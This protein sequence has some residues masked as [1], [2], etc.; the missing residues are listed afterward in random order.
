[1]KRAILFILITFLF[2]F[3]PVSAQ[4]IK[5]PE[6]VFGFQM[7]TDKKLINWQQIVSYFNLLAENSKRVQVVELGRTTLNRPM[8]MAIIGAEEALKNLE[9]YQKIQ[10]QLA[11][12]SDL[13][14]TNV[15]TLIQEGKLVFLITLNIHSTEI[16]SSQESVELAYEL[17]TSKDLEI[18]KILDNVI[19]LLVPSLNPDG[20]D[21]ITK[22]YLQDLGTEYEGSRMPM[23]YHYYADHDNNRD[24]FFFNLIESQHVAKVL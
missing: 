11:R 19:I 2:Q 21:M 13:T 3:Q 24:W 6:E 8:I 1:M 9:T 17:A 16:A 20:K 4:S 23:K 22:W 7:G 18:Q 15:A 12:P 5:S 10:Q 14:E